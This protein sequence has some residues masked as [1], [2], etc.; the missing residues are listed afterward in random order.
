MKNKIR[1][2]KEVNQ[3]TLMENFHQPD[4]NQNTNI[5]EAYNQLILQLQEM[6]DK[7]ALEKIVKRTESHITYGSITPYTNSG[8]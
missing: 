2:L 4:L 6:L 1:N 3:A 5:N 7:C 8:K